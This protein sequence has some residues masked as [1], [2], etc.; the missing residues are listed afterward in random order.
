MKKWRRDAIDEESIFYWPFTS[1]N[2]GCNSTCAMCIYH[3]DFHQKTGR[4]EVPWRPILNVAQYLHYCI[5]NVQIVTCRKKEYLSLM[6]L[7]FFWKQ[8]YTSLLSPIFRCPSLDI[9]D[10]KC[11]NTLL[12]SGEALNPSFNFSWGSQTCTF[13]IVDWLSV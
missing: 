5:P 8:I 6:T 12:S 7:F 3:I 10:S 1:Q 9:F 4:K 11:Q 2:G 13:G